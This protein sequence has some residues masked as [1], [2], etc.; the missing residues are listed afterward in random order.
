MADLRDRIKDKIGPTMRIG[1][2]DAELFDGPGAERIEDWV[3]WI[4]DA[5]I[6][7]RDEELAN[8]KSSLMDVENVIRRWR[9]G[10][11]IDDTEAMHAIARLVEN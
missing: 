1:L 11:F 9:Q 4:T 3:T 2:Q 10:E 6:A 7:V 5:V 8:T